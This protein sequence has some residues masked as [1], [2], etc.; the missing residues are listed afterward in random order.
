MEKRA[1]AEAVSRPH[2]GSL[3]WYV[4]IVLVI[5]LGYAVGGAF[6]FGTAFLGWFQ[7]VSDPTGRLCLQLFGMGMLGASVAC[8]KWWSID[9]D[10]AQMDETVRPV[11][12]D[13]FGYVTTILGGGTTG[14]VLYLV[15]RY[16]VTMAVTETVGTVRVGA[17]V[18]IAFTGGLFEFQVLDMLGGLLKKIRSHVAAAPTDESEI[19][20]Q[21]EANRPEDSR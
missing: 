14:L 1:E 20:T 15:L 12:L 10:D 16:G 9:H 21:G 5:A 17:A 8:S 7:R 11:P 2:H 6:A 3:W 19:G 4:P 13:W 18:V